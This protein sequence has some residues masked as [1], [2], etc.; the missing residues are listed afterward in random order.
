M[1]KKPRI[2]IIKGLDRIILLLAILSLF[3]GFYL[4][5]SGYHDQL[6]WTPEYSK[7]YQD[8]KVA[9]DKD[10]QDFLDGKTKWDLSGMI[11]EGEPPKFS[12]FAILHT[13]AAGSIT[14]V[15]VFAIVFFG[16]KGITRLTRKISLWIIRGFKE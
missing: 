3:F 11:L 7:W 10:K 13:I 14:S 1:A 15:V 5:A 2:N 9:S 8:C 6:R 12:K 4:G 16:L